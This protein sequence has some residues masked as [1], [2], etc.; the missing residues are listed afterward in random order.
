MGWSSHFH[1]PAPKLWCVPWPE[2]FQPLKGR[3][4]WLR[5]APARGA[6]LEGSSWAC[7]RPAPALS[8]C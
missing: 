3:P 8:A 1:R 4:Q 6:A 2:Q 5:A 7:R